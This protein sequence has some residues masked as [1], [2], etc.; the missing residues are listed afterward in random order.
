MQTIGHKI[1]SL[2]SSPSTNDYLKNIAGRNGEHGLVVTA[3]Q[4]TAGRGQGGRQWESQKGLGLY[5]SVLLKPEIPLDY[6][7]L[8]SLLPAIAV[9]HAVADF[10][11]RPAGVKWPND[12]MVHGRKIAGILTE[13]TIRNSQLLYA[14]IGMG[15]NVRHRVRH[16]A[17]FDGRAGSLFTESGRDFEITSVLDQIIF[18]LNLLIKYDKFD[19]WRTQLIDR[20]QQLCVHMHRPVSRPRGIFR[21]LNGAGQAVVEMKNGQKIVTARFDHTD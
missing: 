1:I 9:A 13:T 17:A 18:Q 6:I 5:C 8:L 2:E 21:G 14:V 12:V 11:K 3:R 4:Q 19:A 20:W 16:L 7:G 15:V 10:I